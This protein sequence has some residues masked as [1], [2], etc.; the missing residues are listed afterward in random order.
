MNMR[1]D[2]QVIGAGPRKVICLH[3]WFGHASGWE[4]LVQHMDQ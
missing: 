4:P 1:H 2:A 3:G